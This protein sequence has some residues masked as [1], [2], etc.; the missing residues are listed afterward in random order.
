MPTVTSIDADGYH[1]DFYD[2]I[3]AYIF[4]EKSPTSPNFHGGFMKAVDIIAEFK[5]K[6]FFIEMK[7]YRDKEDQ[8]V[9]SE[10]MSEEEKKQKKDALKW[11]KNYLKY[12]FRDTYL[13]RYAEAGTPK[14]D[15]HYICLLSL[16]SGV[17]RTV[18]EQL[19]KELPIGKKGKRWN[20][21]LATTC[22]VIDVDGWNRTLSTYATVSLL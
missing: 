3:S 6:I 18:K 19:N 1:F 17:L 13:Y 21:S 12:K 4:D 10:M 8:F 20:R 15:I 22:Q 7:D 14:K 16:S 11:L 9:E 5:D 2:A